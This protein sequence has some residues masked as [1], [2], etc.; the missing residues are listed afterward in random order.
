MKPLIKVVE[1]QL[2]FWASSSLLKYIFSKYTIEWHLLCDDIKNTE[3]SAE[4]KRELLAIK[5]K[6]YLWHSSY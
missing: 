3:H 6:V 1:L 2:K 4:F 5:E